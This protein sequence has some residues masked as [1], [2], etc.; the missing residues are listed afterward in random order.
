MHGT[1]P[2][3]RAI[4][5]VIEAQSETCPN[6]SMLVQWYIIVE[7]CSTLYDGSTSLMALQT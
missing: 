4:V 2:T 3:P 5:V 1:A 7:D 6:H